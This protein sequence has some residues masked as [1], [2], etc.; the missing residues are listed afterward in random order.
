M[1]SDAARQASAEARKK[2]SGHNAGKGNRAVAKHVADQHKSLVWGA[3]KGAL[4]PSELGGGVVAGIR[5]AHAYNA[6]LDAKKAK[7]K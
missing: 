3:V 1:W 7:K 4:T 2:A 5:S 6:G